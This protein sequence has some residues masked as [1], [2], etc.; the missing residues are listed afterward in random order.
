MRL[1]FPHYKQAEGKDCGPTCLRIIAK[2][3]KKTIPV[4]KL[5]ELCTTTREGTSLLGISDGAE[6]IGLRTLGAKV[7]L[8]KLS[9]IPLPCI[10]HW[11]T[12][13][14]VV[15]YKVK[16]GRYYISDPAHG[17][18]NYNKR[19]FVK[20]WVGENEENEVEN[21]DVG[22]VLIL[23][24]TPKFYSRDYE[25]ETK[26]SYD[27]NFL[28]KYLF[29][30][31]RFIYQLAI[32][33]IVSSLLQLIFPFLTQSIVDIGIKN[34]DIDFIYLVL[35]AQL[36]LFIGRTSVEVIRSWIL[37]HLSTRI[38][39]S[40]ISDFFYKLMKLPISYF[41]VRL[42]GDLMQRIHDHER[43]ERI[44]TT[45]SLNVLFS[46]VNII[47]FGFVLLYYNVQIFMVFILGSVLFLFWVLIFLKKRR[48][49][50]YRRFSQMGSE[51][52]KVIEL[53]NG[54]Q[55]IKIHNAEKKMRWE[56]EY[57]QVRLFN[58]SVDNL[59]LEQLQSVGSSFINELKNILITILSAKLVIDGE[60][61]LGMMLA[62]SYIVGQLNSPIFELISFIREI[63]DAN[64]AMERLGEIHNK[65]DEDIENFMKTDD[66]DINSDIKL[67]N[68][69]FKYNGSK[70][71]VL[72][73]LNLTIPKNKITAVVGLSG[74]GKTT[75]MK[76]LL[77]FYEP[78]VGEISLGDVKLTNI[79]PR[80]WRN[81]FGVV[82]QEGYIFNDTIA[83]NIAV[84]V[85]EIDK[86]K[87]FHAVEVAN[88]K[89]FI[90][91]LPSDYNTMVGMEG[92]GLSTGQKQ[93][94]LIAR[95]IYKDPNFIFFDE[96]TSALDSKNENEIITQM[97]RF[98][99]DKTV[100]VIAHRLSTI[101][102]AD[103]IV[104]LDN[105]EIVE[106]GNHDDLIRNEGYYFELVKN[107]LELVE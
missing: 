9:K 95:A 3:Y 47:V 91:S 85:D 40:L 51:Q 73:N 56:W 59:K 39:I 33:L 1:R 24:P 68:V 82:L 7:S 78:S 93:R 96:A 88:I 38:N 94:I 80:S 76:L 21:N 103:Q 36:S 25:E 13:H 53:I 12:Y 18:I 90:E 60:I 32:G 54:M 71:F 86:K 81:S 42:T 23:E 61:T 49:L 8:K 41:D 19:E 16:R 50:D 31:K 57:T 37:L 66:F 74:S 77:G 101:K 10:I 72:K 46:F 84:G 99:K 28:F 104:V 92:V 30:Y 52:S 65:S 79:S 55:E 75:L 69:S 20:G 102:N 87:L 100:C 5:R 105:G 64:I 83:N 35:F 98:F 17:L 107:Q 58:I 63:Q 45:S 89:G 48:K 6:E 15:L 62:I 2:Y 43:I 26:R 106:T 70:D 14:Y 27:L 34:K 67:K 29:Q 97:N 11:G 4:Q 44:L 22:V